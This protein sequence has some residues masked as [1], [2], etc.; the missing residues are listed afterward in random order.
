[1]KTVQIFGSSS[2]AFAAHLFSA[3]TCASCWAIFGPSLALLFGSGGAEF[4]AIA[5]PYAPLAL[6]LSALGLGSSFYGLWKKRDASAKLPFQMATVFTILS[7]IGW[8]GSA[9]YTVLTLVKG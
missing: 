2:V 3:L 9:A 5:R 4:L 8:I 1:M 6:A 7:S